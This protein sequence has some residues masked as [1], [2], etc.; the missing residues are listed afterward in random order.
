V[1]PILQLPDG[2]NVIVIDSPHSSKAKLAY[3]GGNCSIQGFDGDGVDQFWTVTGDNV[4]SLAMVD[5]NLDGHKELIV[6]SEDYDLRVFSGDE[7]IGEISEADA[8]TCL[9]PVDGGSL[10]AYALA[11]GSIGVYNGLERLW[12]AKSKSQPIALFSYDVNDDG[13][14]ELV[15]GWS[16]GKVEA[17]S[18]KTG[19]IVYKD[20][21]DSAVAGIVKADYKMDGNEELICCSVEGEVRGYLPTSKKEG[22]GFEDMVGDQEALSRLNQIK[23]SLLQEL[24]NFD[25]NEQTMKVSGDERTSLSSKMG[26]IPAGTT[27]RTEFSVV[28]ASENVAIGPHLVLS[29]QTSND[30]LIKCVAVFAEGLF[31]GE[32]Y[33]SHPP[34]E[35]LGAE[36]RIPFYPPKDVP[37]ELHVKALVGYS[38][39]D[40]FHVFEIH[41]PLPRFALYVPCASTTKPSPAS[42]VEFQLTERVSRV[43]SWLS[44]SFLFEP[45]E[46]MVTSPYLQVAF[47]SMR[48]QTPVIIKFDPQDMGK[49]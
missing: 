38:D 17:R 28:L 30:T 5:F 4:S 35:T 13:V 23:Q 36:V 33:I 12:R 9:C 29:V 47:L 8:I 48:T 6:G 1:Y 24:K 27:I 25:S 44:Q 19:E 20:T 16:S 40:Q 15:T 32:S 37:Q 46:D 41:R 43:Q 21:L 3:V 39:N 10:Y 22:T 14:N 42:Y 34:E 49:V 7:L 26:V 31:E 11:N 2:A 45:G 18:D